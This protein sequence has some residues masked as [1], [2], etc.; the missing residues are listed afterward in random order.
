M[1]GTPAQSIDTKVNAVVVPGTGFTGPATQAVARVPGIDD[2]Q[3]QHAATQA[4]RQCPV[5][6][7]LSAIPSTLDVRLAVE[8]F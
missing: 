4:E 7:A 3:L 6:R 5:S 2:A 1:A 8:E